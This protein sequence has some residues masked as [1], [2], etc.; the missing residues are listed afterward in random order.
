GATVPEASA[1]IQQICRERGAPLQQLGRDF[2]FRYEPGWV[3]S[4]GPSS[5]LIR[6]ARVQVTTRRQAWPAMGL[7]LLGEHQAANAAVAVGCIEQLRAKG[8]PISD[9]A[10][11]E[12]LATVRWPA[13]MEVLGGRPLVIL[14][15]AHNVASARAF[16]ETLQASFAPARHWL[17]FAC[18][19]DKDV[20]G[21]LRVLAPA[22]H[23]AFL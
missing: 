12:G 20:A 10:V 13:R 1:V 19:N 18:S 14:D 8:W 21:I 17:I 4:G 16:V 2:H 22:F 5:P 23:H 6:R 3:E 7:G 15:C 11:V 9:R